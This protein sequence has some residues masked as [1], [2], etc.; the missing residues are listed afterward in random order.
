MGV[1]ELSALLWR[2]RELLEVLQFKLEVE[3]LLLT[4][5]NTR[6]LNRASAET[7]QVS[8]HIRDLGLART[9]EVA[10]V[11]NEWGVAE[12]STLGDLIE[13]SPEPIWTDILGSHLK[14]FA[15]LVEKI[16]IARDAN[17][18]LLR[19]ANRATQDTIGDLDI[20]PATYNA[21]GTSSTS[22]SGSSAPGS[23]GSGSSGASP[24]ARLLDEEG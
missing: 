3:Q 9:V 7:E 16:Q 18:A 1:H 10:A 22:G 14:G 21:S 23:A 6:W 15:D 2:E 24:A 13:H 20:G 8:G 5:G 17:L 11:A 19:E 4:T 12:N